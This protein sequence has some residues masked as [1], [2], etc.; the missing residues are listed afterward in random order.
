MK[1]CMDTMETLSRRD[2]HLRSS[3]FSIGTRLG[4]NVVVKGKDYYHLSNLNFFAT[5]VYQGPPLIIP[6]SNTT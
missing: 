6:T 3:L 1:M 5:A 4:G 2:I